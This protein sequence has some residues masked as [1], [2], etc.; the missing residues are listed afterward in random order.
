M[1]TAVHLCS[2]FYFSIFHF[3]TE[4]QIFAVLE[5]DQNGLEMIALLVKYRLK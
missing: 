4:K 5:E 2:F 3:E 1:D